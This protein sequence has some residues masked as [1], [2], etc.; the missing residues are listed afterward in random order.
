MRTARRSVFASWHNVGMF[1]ASP[2]G[3]G[4]F[5]ASV[6]VSS[7]GYECWCEL[8]VPLPR[9]LTYVSYQ[10]VSEPDLREAIYRIAVCELTVLVLAFFLACA[11]NDPCSR[12]FID[13]RTRG[14]RACGVIFPLPSSV[15][16]LV[17]EEAFMKVF[18]DSSFDLTHALLPFRRT[19]ETNLCASSRVE[20]FSSSIAEAAVERVEVVTVLGRK[21]GT[22]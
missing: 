6:P 5:C 4:P 12:W 11:R 20:W 22:H 3:C 8:I 15:G 7:S 2:S 14:G 1:A 18:D 21:G 19:Q 13:E 10:I 16:R 9:L 17:D